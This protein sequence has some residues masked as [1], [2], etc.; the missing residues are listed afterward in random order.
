M[1]AA[2][3]SSTP[4][5]KSRRGAGPDAVTGHAS[6]ALNRSRGCKTIGLGTHLPPK[7]FGLCG[8]YPSAFTILEIKYEGR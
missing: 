7:D 3:T 6:P 4:L 5:A 8:S 1:G 2:G